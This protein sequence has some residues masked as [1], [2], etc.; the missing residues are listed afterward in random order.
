MAGIPCGAR[1]RGRVRGR[2]QLRRPPPGAAAAVRRAQGHC[3]VASRRADDGAGP[4][5]R[6]SR[7]TCW[8]CRT[9][10][11]RSS[12]LRQAA[13]RCFWSSMT[14]RGSTGRAL[15][16]SDSS[17]DGSARYRSG[18]S[19]P[20]APARTSFL[21]QAGLPTLHHPAADRHRRAR[22]ARQLLP[23]MSPRVRQRLLTEAQGNP[24]A[25]LEL[26]AALD[27][28]PDGDRS[29]LTASCGAPAVPPAPGDVR[30]PAAVAATADPA[31]AARSR[32]RRHW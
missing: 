8:C 18:C 30:R 24:L 20:P 29:G 1:G 10:P 26:P 22:A 5:G 17:R 28:A 21:G 23:A 19:P 4:A 3:R 7:W 12:P 11:W 31:P 25:L 15:P 16:C 13:R 27:A 32:P 2:G 9:Q 6:A 14:S